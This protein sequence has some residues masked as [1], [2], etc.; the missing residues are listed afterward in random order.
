MMRMSTAQLYATTTAAIT[1]KQSDLAN[2][3][4]QLSTG[5]R[6]SSLADD[7]AGAAQ[8]S[9]LNSDLSANTQFT[10]N[11]TF[12]T[13]RL[14]F[15]ENIVGSVIDNLQSVRET[16]VNA[17]NSTLSDS[18]RK[19][20]AGKLR[21]SLGSLVGLGNTAD[22]QGGYLF[23]GFRDSAPPFAGN[24]LAVNYNADDGNRSVNV[25]QTRS[26]AIG[27]NG[28]DVFMRIPTGNGV[29]ASSA[30]AA[31]AGSGVI[32][33]GSVTNPALLSGNNYEIR[34][35][36]SASG[37]TYD[38]V[39]TTA[40]TT[41]SSGT[42]YS[43]PAAIA[44][45]GISVGIDG[46]PANGDRFTIA[47]SGN[48]S[49]F[50][51]VSNAI[52]ALETP[53]NG[54]TSKI[55]NAVRASLTDLDQVISH[56]ANNRATAGSRMNELDQLAQLGASREVDLKS[57]LSA[58]QDIDYAKTISDFT[59]TQTGLQAALASYTKIAGQNLFDYLR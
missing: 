14:S 53:S 29:F 18:D 7:P 1:A 4:N 19:T 33:S 24:G 16:M 48:Q 27:L 56:V 30:A 37:T 15:T 32:D 8:A 12:A 25:T 11:R 59:V 10:Q 17:G 28:G 47:P 49:L 43:A 3:Q 40:G 26:M 2:I 5:K 57:N 21:E 46:V 13:Q 9:T 55:S 36:T 42:P 45:P 23:G 58:V 38:V 20:L 50:A 41:V 51:V 39:D 52:S 31:N 44:L 34:F 54:N 22:G 35:Q 6:I